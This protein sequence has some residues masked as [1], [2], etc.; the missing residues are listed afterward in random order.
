[1]GSLKK[2]KMDE[3]IAEDIDETIAMLKSST[4]DSYESEINLTEPGMDQVPSMT[5]PS[6]ESQYS[7]ARPSTP[8]RPSQVSMASHQETDVPEHAIV[9]IHDMLKRN[10][11]NAVASAT[12]KWREKAGIRKQLSFN[13]GSSAS[14]M[15]QE[16]TATAAE[17][18]LEMLKRNEVKA[19]ADVSN[20]WLDSVGIRR[21]MSF[22]SENTMSSVN[23]INQGSV[24]T[25]LSSMDRSMTIIDGCASES[26]GNITPDKIPQV[27]VNQEAYKEQRIVRQPS[28]QNTDLRPVVTVDN[29]LL[30]KIMAR[31]DS[32]R[33]ITLTD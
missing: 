24:S 29:S 15:T 3:R 8:S 14:Q 23:S 9:A 7:I 33:L 2:Y 1:M 25:K 20:K 28:E 12:D 11:V 32:S 17:Q 27:S 31:L 22:Q 16:S 6:M 18:E 30:I 10:E 13:S 4:T 21:Q 5:S 26:F 19:V